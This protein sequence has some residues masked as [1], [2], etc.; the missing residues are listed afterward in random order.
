MVNLTKSNPRCRKKLIETAYKIID[1]FDNNKIEQFIKTYKYILKDFMTNCPI[2]VKFNILKYVQ[3]Q[4]F[5]NILKTCK[6]WHELRDSKHE[7]KWMDALKILEHEHL[8]VVDRHPHIRFWTW[9]QIKT[10]HCSYKTSWFNIY[11][12][13]L[14]YKDKST[15]H[16]VYRTFSEIDSNPFHKSRNGL[17][18]YGCFMIWNWKYHN[19]N[20]LDEDH[21]R[22][23]ISTT[24]SNFLGV[25]PGHML[26]KH[27]IV[28]YIITYAHKHNLVEIN[29]RLINK[30]R[31]TKYPPVKIELTQDLINLDRPTK[32]N[33]YRNDNN[34]RT[35]SI[36]NKEGKYPTHITATNSLKLIAHHLYPLTDYRFSTLISLN[37]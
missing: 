16:N 24:L 27:D 15:Y 33:Q 5:Q 19:H 32:T 8:L 20:Y 22:Y 10:I 26:T 11:K 21:K 31:K 17:L 13:M 23:V 14:W 2:S 9:D 4:D 3:L 34:Y 1:N 7:N 29:K 18:Y 30:K 28:K 12:F 35:S 37:D 36:T 25:L 6:R